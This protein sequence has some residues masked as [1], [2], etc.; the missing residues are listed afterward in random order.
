[1]DNYNEA[2]SPEQPLN[3]QGLLRIPRSASLN[4]DD[5]S[6]CPPAMVLTTPHRNGCK[7]SDVV[8][9]T[10]TSAPLVKD[11]GMDKDTVMEED[12]SNIPALEP[13]NPKLTYKAPS[14][15]LPKDDSHPET[16][17]LTH[18]KKLKATL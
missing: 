11:N 9:V 1:M 3:G 18:K 5:N 7:G 13:Y 4:V 14:R 15:S 6:K 8:K 12:R 17:F 10:T 16:G 2:P